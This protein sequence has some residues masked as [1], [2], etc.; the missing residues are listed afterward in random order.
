[1]PDFDPVEEVPFFHRA[2]VSK[3]DYATQKR[4][5]TETRKELKTAIELLIQAETAL[6]MC[7]SSF[8]PTGEGMRRIAESIR[9]WRGGRGE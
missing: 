4:E 7:G 1:M 5:L 6:F 2:D 8:C 9:V 3:H